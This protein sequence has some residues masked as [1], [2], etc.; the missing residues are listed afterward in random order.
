LGLSTAFSL[1]AL[2]CG[3]PDVGE[4]TEQR[5]TVTL[6]ALS[7]QPSVA[8]VDTATTGL[9]VQR[10]FVSA[11][12]MTL[13]PC[14]EDAASIVLPARGYDLLDSPSEEVTTAVTDLCA[15]QLD[16]DPVSDAATEG[17]PD[18]ATL[19]AEA[20]APSDQALSFVSDRSHALRFEA[21]G[22]AAPGP[23]LIVGFDLAL[24]LTGLPL[25]PGDAMPPTDMTEA[26]SD[27]F[28]SQLRS[29]VALYAD[30][31]ENQRLDDDETTPI[32]IASASR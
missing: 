18:G 24:W 6:N 9:S 30:S 29:A 2:A 4:I 25:P 3:G 7:S 19:Y 26:E 32:A 31:N 27:L 20:K 10:A 16:L 1:T 21:K 14:D 23:S 13:V 15:V 8:A 17:V 28:D 12:A 11:S 22:G 5:V